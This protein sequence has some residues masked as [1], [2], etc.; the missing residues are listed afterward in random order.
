MSVCPNCGANNAG[1]KFCSSC[2]SP[3]PAEQPVYT[4][5]P[6]QPQPVAQPVAQPIVPP[7]YQQPVY[8]QPYQQ[9]PEGFNGFQPRIPE[10]NILTAIIFSILTC[11]VYMYYWIYTLNEDLRA[12]TGNKNGTSGGLVIVLSLITCGFYLYYWFYK[13]GETIDNIKIQRG[14]PNG[15]LGILYLI[16]AVFGLSTVSFAL[17]Q[18]DLNTFAKEQI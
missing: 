16:L 4:A 17:M 9:P 1:G 11:G 10:R 14:R 15:S 8:Q 6:V 12:Y 2:G 7:V 18:K 13:Q 5:Q 3:L